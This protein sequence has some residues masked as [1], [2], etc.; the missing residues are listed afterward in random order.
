MVPETLLKSSILD[1]L[2]TL[3]LT[4]V[5]WECRQMRGELARGENAREC[6]VELSTGMQKK[7]QEEAGKYL[8]QKTDSPTSS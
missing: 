5:A 4:W 7:A 2:V 3:I 6:I 1:I 8:Q